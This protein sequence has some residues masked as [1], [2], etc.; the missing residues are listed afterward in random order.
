MGLFASFRSV[1]E[2]S[3]ICRL[4]TAIANGWISSFKKRFFLGLGSGAKELRQRANILVSGWQTFAIFLHIKFSEQ[5]D[6]LL[7]EN[8]ARRGIWRIDAGTDSR[9]LV[10]RSLSSVIAYSEWMDNIPPVP[11]NL[12]LLHP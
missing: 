9:A 12:S 11:P 2:V 10:S 1:G 4:E 8:T 7:A 5:Y 6:G 3:S